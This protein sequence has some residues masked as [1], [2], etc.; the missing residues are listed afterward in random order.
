MNRNLLPLRPFSTD[1]LG[2]IVAGAKENPEVLWLDGKAIP[3]DQLLER[4]S[5]LQDGA[6]QMKGREKKAL[7]R[8]RRELALRP[9]QAE[10]IGLQKYLEGT[11]RRPVSQEGEGREEEHHGQGVGQE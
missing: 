3:T 11:G 10:L 4:Y 9:Y 6:Q 1:E 8:Y 5:Q 2:A 7:R